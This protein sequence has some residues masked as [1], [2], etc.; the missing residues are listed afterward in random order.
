MIEKLKKKHSGIILILIFLIVL[1]VLGFL[2][3]RLLSG[4]DN[5]ICEN[6]Q[7]IK[8]GNPSAPVPSY[9]CSKVQNS[10]N[11]SS[12][13]KKTLNINDIQKVDPVQTT[14]TLVNQIPNANPVNIGMIKQ[15]LRLFEPVY[16]ISMILGTK[17]CKMLRP[18]DSPQNCDQI[19][20]DIQGGINKILY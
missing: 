17:F 9:A 3:L 20:S 13:D 5:W 4:E 18:P 19:K 7:W 12:S 15:G 10:Q 14:Q 1:I 6:G 16:D 11:T 8:H 2:T